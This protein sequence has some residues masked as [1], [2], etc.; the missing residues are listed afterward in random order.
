M[1][2]FGGGRASRRVRRVRS[3]PDRDHTAV[4]KFGGKTQMTLNFGQ[5]AHDGSTYPADWHATMSGFP[6]AG[7]ALLFDPAGALLVVKPN[8]KPHWEIP[9]GIAHEGESPHA[10]CRRE[11]LEEVGIDRLPG[12]LLCVDWVPPE[13][14]CRAMFA[15]IFDGGVIGE[16]LLGM[17]RPCDDELDSIEFVGLDE[18]MAR[19]SAR[20]ARRVAGA[21]RARHTGTTVFLEHGHIVT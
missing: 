18:V 4:K 17:L 5:P 1:R 16:D 11:V 8:Y 2:F 9:G 21:L 3:Y 7:G 20:L 14:N 15:F 12:R 19:L 13:P 10:T 6:A